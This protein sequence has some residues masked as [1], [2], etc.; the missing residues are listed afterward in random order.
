MILLD[1][2]VV[3]EAMKPSP[4]PQVRRWLDRQIPE[5]L[6]LSSVTVA[7]VRLG[8]AVLADG[9]RKSRFQ[10]MLD[11]VLGEFA[12]RVLP[13]DSPSAEAYARLAAQAR[14]S[15]RGFPIPDGYIAAIAASR[16]FLVATR[17]RSAF[18]A[19]GVAI[20]D[21]WKPAGSD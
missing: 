11:H 14:L 7:E 3:S 10:S 12:T 20:V 19:A 8:I 9:K 13:F 17:D 4:D 6:F 2:N 15:G 18:E 1:T 5:T 16:G 21:P